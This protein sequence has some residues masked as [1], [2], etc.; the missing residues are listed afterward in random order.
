M[1][2]RPPPSTGIETIDD[3]APQQQPTFGT[4]E[5]YIPD[6]DDDGMED[7]SE[8]AVDADLPNQGTLILNGVHSLPSPIPIPGLPAI[9]AS[10][11][12]PTATPFTP[13]AYLHSSRFPANPPTALLPI[14]SIE[15]GDVVADLGHMQEMVHPSASAAP[16]GMSFYMGEAQQGPSTAT[17][18]TRAHHIGAGNATV[19]GQSVVQGASR[20]FLIVGSISGQGTTQHGGPTNPVSPALMYDAI[21]SNDASSSRSSTPGDP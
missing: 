8:M 21:T 11:L 12:V 5:P 19:A 6:D 4:Q 2:R 10:T 7:I 14:T 15:D 17:G 16:V 18:S 3:T 9:T 1:N 20:A 13:A